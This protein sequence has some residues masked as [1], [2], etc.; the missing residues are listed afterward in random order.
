MGGLGGLGSIVLPADDWAMVRGF[1]VDVGLVRARAPQ[2]G[3][4]WSGCNSARAA[5]AASI[6]R[7]EPG[8]RTDMDGNGGDMA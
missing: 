7:G 5:A 4:Y 6:Y 2:M 1:A 3:D 8:S